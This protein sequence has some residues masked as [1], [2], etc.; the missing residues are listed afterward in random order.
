MVIRSI[1]PEGTGFLAGANATVITAPYAP[2]G[3]IMVG[4]SETEVTIPVL[5]EDQKVARSFIMNEFNPGFMIGTRMRAVVTGSPQHWMEGVIDGFNFHTNTLTLLIDLTSS[6]ESYGSY[7]QWNLTVAGEPGIRGP[8]GVQGPQ[9]MPGNPGGPVG[10]IGPE[11]PR[12]APATIQIGTVVAG[13]PGDPPEVTLTPG[14]PTPTPIVDGVLNFVL[15]RGE[16]GEKG[17]TSYGGPEGPPGPAQTITGTVSAVGNLPSTGNPG[18][19]YIVG[20]GDLY[21]WDASIANWRLV[22]NLRGPPGATGNVGA[23]GPI[24]PMPSPEDIVAAVSDVVDPE[25]YVW[26]DGSR[27]FLAVARGVAPA[28]TAN[29]NTIPTAAW[30]QARDAARQT[31]IEA[32]ANDHF[33][34]RTGTA[35]MSATRL[36]AT[37]G[38]NQ[39]VISSFD[40]TQ[41]SGMG[42]M[43]GINRRLYFVGVTSAGQWSG[44]ATS[45]AY[46][47][48]RDATFGVPA[49][50]VPD[51]LVAGGRV[52]ADQHVTSF[53]GRIISRSNG[54]PGF[55]CFN[56]SRNSAAGVFLGTAG[57]GWGRA[58]ADGNNVDTLAYSRLS[59][60]RFI[61][62][63]NA[64]L[65]V[66]GHPAAVTSEFTANVVVR[67]TLW[68]GAAGPVCDERIKQNIT[69]SKIDALGAL[70][71]LN[72][73]EYDLRPEVHE[74]YG[75]SRKRHA[76]VG[77]VSQQVA[78]YIP[79]AIT[80]APDRPDQDS[81]PK[82]MPKNVQG[83]RTDDLVF[84]LIRAVQQLSN[85]VTELKAKVDGRS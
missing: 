75:G 62:S 41:N 10:P 36:Q 30:V 82:N 77:L 16:R 25:S 28:P 5:A 59:D 39:A 40:T 12:G 54:T 78:Q 80:Q 66:H 60:G 17:E 19:G 3:P 4:T 49:F 76:N 21:V 70:N 44:G 52:H 63:S 79:E 22:G 65:E 48:P 29:D 24:G 26:R 7:G 71:K 67:G 11:G 15:P 42:M 72:V 69:P 37:A 9:G 55:T 38:T 85:E 1:A 64:G 33:M 43:M 81:L 46:L 2:R 6:D 34:P 14:V 58:T 23:M 31:A 68:Y 35:M 57:I 20:D 61:V 56:P 45:F 32:W 27:P 74:W 83:L 73:V 13:E 51:G 8:E 84:Y 47:D 50:Y 53:G 18:Q